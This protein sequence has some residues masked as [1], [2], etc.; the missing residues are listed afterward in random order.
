MSP[1]SSCL[2]KEGLYQNLAAFLFDT[3]IEV[4]AFFSGRK[5]VYTFRNA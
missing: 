5:I 3:H 2:Y 1:E 4:I